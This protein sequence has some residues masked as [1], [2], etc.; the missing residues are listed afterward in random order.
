MTMPIAITDTT[1]DADAIMVALLRRTPVW[2]KLQLMGDLNRMTRS[3]ALASLRQ[4]QPALSDVALYRQLADCLLGEA[5]A[6]AAYGPHDPPLVD[7]NGL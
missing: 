6:L 7:N 5:L 4:Q 3:I 2:R 1:T